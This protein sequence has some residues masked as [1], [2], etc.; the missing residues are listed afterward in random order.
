MD[1]RTQM[2]GRQVA[3]VE[4]QVKVIKDRMPATYASIQS[5]AKGMGRGAFA[6]V[7]RSL[8]GTPNLFWAMER[9][10]VMGTPFSADQ[11]I[12]ADVA[13]AMVSFGA[14]SVVIWADGDGAH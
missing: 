6:L 10:H 1:G 11:P 13:T 9:G 7:R 8:A 14:T 5:K 2:Q 4:A 3:E 12:A